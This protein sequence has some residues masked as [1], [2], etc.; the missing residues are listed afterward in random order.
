VVVDCEEGTA[1]GSVVIQGTTD[2]ATDTIII[3]VDGNIVSTISP[4]SIGNWQA[5]VDITE[6]THSIQALAQ[7]NESETSSSVEATLTVQCDTPSPPGDGG[8]GKDKD[9][10]K[11]KGNGNSKEVTI[12]DT[13]GNLDCSNKMHDQVKK[14]KPDYFVALGNLCSGSDLSEFKDTYSDFNNDKKLKCL[15]G[16]RESEKSGNLELFKES[17]KYCGDHWYLKTGNKKVLMIGFNTFGDINLQTN[18]AQ[19]LIDDSKLMKG[20]KTILLFGHEPA[21][22]PPGSEYQ[23]KDTIVQMYSE[24]KSKIPEGVKFY[25][26]AS[27]D[28]LMAESENGHWFIS[29]AGSEEESSSGK[30]NS[31][32]IFVS[33]EE[34]GY[35]KIKI[36][37][38]NGKISS[39]HFYDLDGKLIR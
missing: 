3:L 13:A 5:T 17:K 22:T 23:S 19:S 29:G 35:L 31:K 9:K 10:D 2:L 20:V 18:W 38:H 37:D 24:L 28:H 33:T 4:D 21:H 7:D 36:N 14:D 12:I 26:I 15:I 39:S 30:T 6:G 25:E 1:S 11:D 27:H 34:E 32:W 8:D 16:D